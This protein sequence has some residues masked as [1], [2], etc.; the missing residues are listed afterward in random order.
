MGA[1]PKRTRSARARYTA[2]RSPKARD[3]YLLIGLGLLVVLGVVIWAAGLR[4]AREDVPGFE[5]YA[6]ELRGL[7]AKIADL[8]RRRP[9]TLHSASADTWLDEFQL[10]LDR[11]LQ[12]GLD[13]A[14]GDR[15]EFKA[16]RAA[17]ERT[18][19]AIRNALPGD[20]WAP[21]LESALTHVP[22][23]RRN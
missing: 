17:L 10:V 12:M 14:V 15:V 16:Y 7:N 6:E 20:E 19:D 13:G 22:E 11:I 1:V 4:V 2:K 21:I 18:R 8:G 9:A 23:Y 5:D 3:R